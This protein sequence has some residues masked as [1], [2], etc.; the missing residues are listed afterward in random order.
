MSL[1][2]SASDSDRAASKPG[3][4]CSRFMISETAA[5][6]DQELNSLFEDM[7]LPKMQGQGK[8]L[9]EC[10]VSVKQVVKTPMSIDELECQ[11]EFYKGS[12]QIFFTSSSI[13]YKAVNSI[14]KKVMETGMH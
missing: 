1:M 3:E 13:L 2:A 8:T 12:I 6:A 7:G 5:L 4:A 11:M 14:H 9:E 10:K